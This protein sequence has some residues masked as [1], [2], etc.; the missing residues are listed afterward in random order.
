MLRGRPDDL[1]TEV[2]L[3]VALLEDPGRRHPAADGRA[4]RRAASGPATSP[5]GPTSRPADGAGRRRRPSTGARPGALLAVAY[6]D[7]IAQ[8]RG[9]PGRFVLRGGTEGWVAATDALAREPFLAVAEVDGRRRNGRIRLA[10]PLAADQLDDVAGDQVVEHSRLVW[11]RDRDELVDRAERQLG[12]LRLGTVER[13]PRPGLATT[14]ALLDRVR[15]HRPRRPAR[16]RRAP[17]TCSARVGFLH[18]RVG[19]PWPDLSTAAL[20]RTLDDWLAPWLAGATGRGDL[21]RL[22]LA[23]IL[24]SLV[25]G[26]VVRRPRPPGPRRP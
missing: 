14:T 22:D 5:A 4:L 24:R 12:R 26:Q 25:P 7:R 19:E 15:V 1:P 11:D 2:G 23:A 21:D 6:P 20:R 13:R 18:A 9:G 17:A 10:A 8:A 3:R 16:G